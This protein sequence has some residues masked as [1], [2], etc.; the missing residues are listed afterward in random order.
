MKK[1]VVINKNISL[2]VFCLYFN[3]ANTDSNVFSHCRHEMLKGPKDYVN[4]EILNNEKCKNGKYW[5]TKDEI[6]QKDSKYFETRG[7]TEKQYNIG[8][9][10]YIVLHHTVDLTKDSVIQAFTENGT[11][12]HYI[13]EL[14]GKVTQL[15]E[16][17]NIAFAQGASRWK[18][19]YNLNFNSISI[20]HVGLGFINQDNDLIKKQINSQNK[21]T[22]PNLDINS[23]IF[24]SYKYEKFVNKNNKFLYEDY[25]L[26][27]E[28]GYNECVPL[29]KNNN[30]YYFAF[31]NKQIESAKKLIFDLQKEYQIPSFNIITHG[32]VAPER[33][34]DV[35]FLYPFQ[36]VGA[37]YPELGETTKLEDTILNSVKEI[38]D[39]TCCKIIQ[40]FG[41]HQDFSSDVFSKVNLSR[42]DGKQ[43]SNN[44][45]FNA[46]KNHYNPF[47]T[48]LNGEMNEYDKYS[49]LSH[50]YDLYNY[51]WKGA[52]VVEDIYFKNKIES[53]SQNGTEQSNKIK[54]VLSKF[55]DKKSAD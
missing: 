46:Y 15:V 54:D 1:N 10:K 9:P 24:F 8:K 36:K 50:A 32:D 2:L 28:V 42:K 3:C 40:C 44:D 39:D 22:D 53:L 12:A 18:N 31:P 41:Y 5:K 17:D 34:E 7:I 51:K 45:L 33:K 16:D 19:D 27:K 11:S 23:R 30:R 38:D 29:Y 6:F 49:L 4:K 20:E 43:L 21:I 14:N 37:Y 55:A 25:K 26:P 52:N 47:L 35:T 48:E 13:I